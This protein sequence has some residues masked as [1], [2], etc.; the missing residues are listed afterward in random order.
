MEA[1]V[2]MPM[3]SEDVQVVAKARRRVFTAE[4]KRRILTAADAWAT[5]RQALTAAE[6]DG[7][8][9]LLSLGREQL[10]WI[11]HE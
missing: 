5:P 10:A 9:A 1:R 3:T 8:L 4:Y 7:V 11:I 6:R 2:E